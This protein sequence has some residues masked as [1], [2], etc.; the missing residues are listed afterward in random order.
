MLSALLI[1]AF[2]YPFVYVIR[3]FI[4]KEPK[5]TGDIDGD[6]NTRP[7]IAL[8]LGVSLGLAALAVTIL[9]LLGGRGSALSVTTAGT[10]LIAYNFMRR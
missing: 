2:V 1:M 4:L 5:Y 7:I 3:R 9:F 6:Q 10:I 8:A